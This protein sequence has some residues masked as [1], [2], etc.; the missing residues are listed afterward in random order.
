MAGVSMNQGRQAFRPKVMSNSAIIFAIVGRCERSQLLWEAA[1]ERRVKSTKVVV[2][3]AE[4]K[5]Q[6]TP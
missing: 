1:V 3:Q 5:T 4:F 6:F 2:T